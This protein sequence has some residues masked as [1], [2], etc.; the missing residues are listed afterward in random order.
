MQIESQ[1]F[2]RIDFE[3]DDLIQLPEGLVGLK[4]CRR[5]I[6]LSD[7]QSADCAWMQ[8]LDRPEVVLTVVSSKRY[9][10]DYQFRMTAHQL[11]GL[12]DSP[13]ELEVLLLVGEKTGSWTVNLK[14]PLLV[15]PQLGIGRQIVLQEDLPVRYA[16]TKTPV[17]ERKSA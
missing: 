1:Q 14:A 10:P 16:L 3:A 11:I 7:P 4:E 5:W 17:P 15:N 6:M 2:G 12:G 9:L 13:E 8:S